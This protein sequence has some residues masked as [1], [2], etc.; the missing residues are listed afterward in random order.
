MADNAGNTVSTVVPTMRYRNARAAIDWLC[1]AFGFEQHLIVAGDNGAIAHAQLAFG[2][3]MVMLGSA[4]D[5]G[6]GKLVRPPVEAG[7]VNTQSPYVIVNDADRHLARAVAAGA[8]IVID[9]KDED[10]GGRGYTCRDPEGHIWNFGT[11]D[12]W[13]A[14]HS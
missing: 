3:G 14:K 4:S 13:A 2:N 11:Y 9:I 1:R 8:E 7:G 5:D 10:Y 6:F 12:P